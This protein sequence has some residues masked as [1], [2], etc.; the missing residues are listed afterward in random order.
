MTNTPDAERGGGCFDG[1]H[2]AGDDEFISCVN[3][4]MVNWIR[5]GP[6]SSGEWTMEMVLRTP[7]SRFDPPPANK[8]PNPFSPKE[9]WPEDDIQ[10]DDVSRPGSETGN[11]HVATPSN[12]SPDAGTEASTPDFADPDELAR[13]K[14]IPMYPVI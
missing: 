3:R 9:L 13:K 14:K 2:I 1:I 4:E 11:D 10:S 6:E 5:R 8:S 7:F 12:L